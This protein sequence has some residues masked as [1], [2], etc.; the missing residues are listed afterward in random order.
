[1]DYAYWIAIFA[2]GAIGA[3]VRELVDDNKIILPFKV[4]DGFALGFVGSMAIGGFIGLVVD[5][6][7]ITA[8]MGG[9]VGASVL[10]RIMP[11]SAVRNVNYDNC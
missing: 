10:E 5:G 4:T 6:S 7:P 9:Y 2:A 8:A 1:M 11:G 3:L